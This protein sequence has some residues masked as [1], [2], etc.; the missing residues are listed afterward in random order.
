MGLVIFWL[1]EGREE[2]RQKRERERGFEDRDG[3]R[4]R[5]RSAAMGLPYPVP[6]PPRS[7]GG[8]RL[9]TAAPA[10]RRKRTVR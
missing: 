3:V 4:H 6:N 9:V 10:P 7:A 2:A 5:L 8:G 1:D